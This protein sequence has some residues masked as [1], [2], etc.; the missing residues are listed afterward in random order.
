MG[1]QVQVTVNRWPSQ[2]EM[3]LAREYSFSTLASYTRFGSSLK[4]RLPLPVS[5]ESTAPS[6]AA[7]G[8]LHSMRTLTSL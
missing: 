4:R 6:F 1:A 3:M 5:Q 7:S 2:R 8:T